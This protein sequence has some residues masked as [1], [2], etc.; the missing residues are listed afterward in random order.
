M[1]IRSIATL[2]LSL[3]LVGAAGTALAEG[4]GDGAAFP[5]KADAFQQKV[6]QRLAHAK[7]RLEKRIAEK[8]VDAARA[9]EMRDRVEARAA[10]IRAATATAAQDGVVTADEAK[11][12]RA[13]GGGHGGHCGGGH[14]H[15]GQ[16]G[17]KS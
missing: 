9:K 11:A 17:D 6:E 4:R 8:K 7:D 3:A 13:A 10:K 14:K 12:V 5:M 16:G 2:A 15:G 1:K